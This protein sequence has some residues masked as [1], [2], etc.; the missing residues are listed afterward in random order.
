MYACPRAIAA[1]VAAW[2]RCDVD[3]NPTI[4]VSDVDRLAAAIRLLEITIRKE[5]AAK[6][7]MARKAA[8]AKAPPEPIARVGHGGRPI[9]SLKQA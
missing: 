8:A 1:A 9:L 7:V 3:G 2:R 6:E 5:S 4:A